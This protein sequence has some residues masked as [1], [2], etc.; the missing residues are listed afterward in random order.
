MRDASD[1]V[2]EPECVQTPDANSYGLPGWAE[3]LEEAIDEGGDE[4]NEENDL[5]GEPRRQ[6]G[7]AG[8]RLSLSNVLGGH[9]WRKAGLDRTL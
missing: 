1:G 9:Q 2:V 5:I 4:E 7:R 6:V 3:R 8:G